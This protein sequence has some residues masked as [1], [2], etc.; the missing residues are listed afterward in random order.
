MAASRMQDNFVGADQGQRS[1]GGTLMNNPFTGSGVS[2]GWGSESSGVGA[3]RQSSTAATGR[4]IPRGRGWDGANGPLYMGKG[5][6]RKLIK[7][8]QVR[9]T[10]QKVNP[11]VSCGS[12]LWLKN[13]QRRTWKTFGIHMFLIIS[14]SGSFSFST[15]TQSCEKTYVLG[16][17]VIFTP[18]TMTFTTH[19]MCVYHRYRVHHFSQT[20]Q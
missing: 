3:V 4:G 9:A 5:T 10:T 20:G 6:E 16:A 15:K 13:T 12:S 2:C 8:A 11:C 18:P 17:S 7:K 14:L 19:S 1:M